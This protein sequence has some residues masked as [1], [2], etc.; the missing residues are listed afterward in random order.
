MMHQSHHTPL[1]LRLLA[2]ALAICLPAFARAQ[3][4]EVWLANEWQLCRIEVDGTG[5]KVL[6]ESPGKRCG[7]PVWSPDGEHIAYDVNNFS[8]KSYRDIQIALIRADGSQR[9]QLGTG[10]IPCW[11]PDGTLI[12]CRSGGKCVM[13]S[14]GTG[15]EI[16]PGFAVSLRWFPRGDRVVSMA[17]SGIAIYD[18]ATGSEQLVSTSPYH[19]QIGYDI[20]S[21]GSKICYSSPNAGLCVATLDDQAPDAIQ[22]EVDRLVPDGIGYHASWSPDGKRIVFAW[23]R[24]PSDLTQL[25]FYDTV[26]RAEPML[27]PGLDLSRH[28]GNPNWSPDGK[29]IVFSQAVSRK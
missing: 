24:H 29:T 16:L 22:A 8:D 1:K 2:V 9:R 14:D 28:N 10:S 4:N 12:L 5:F 19:L 6:D 17:G 15:R 26:T 7:A 20:S 13:N 23:Q 27:V 25:Y 21:D 11:S 18:L 3:P